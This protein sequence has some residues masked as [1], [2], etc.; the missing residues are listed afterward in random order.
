MI[1]DLVQ[2]VKDL[3]LPWLL[4]GLQLSL[5]FSPWPRYFPMLQVQ[6][7]KRCWHCTV[8]IQNVFHFHKDLSFGGGCFLGPHV[9]RMKG[10]SQ[11]VE[12]DLQ[13]LAYATA[14]PDLSRV[15]DLYHS[16]QQRCILNPLSE[17]RDQT[18]NFMVPTW[19]LVRFVSTAATR[20]T[21]RIS[22][23]ALLLPH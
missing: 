17:A 23:F 4:H 6:G 21:P 2:W 15:C 5:R 20:G 19:F 8:K 11:G 10:T 9:R 7:E 14:T 3:V 13:Q 18:Q 16:S 12:S 1:P 22:H